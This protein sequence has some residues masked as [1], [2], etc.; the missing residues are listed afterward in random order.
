MYRF[1]VDIRTGCDLFP[2]GV[3]ERTVDDVV[4]HMSVRPTHGIVR[5]DF[6]HELGWGEEEDDGGN[7]IQYN[8]KFEILIHV[9]VDKFKVSDF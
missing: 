8:E 9:E 4:L 6:R 5:N 7:P 2:R 3:Y 1:C